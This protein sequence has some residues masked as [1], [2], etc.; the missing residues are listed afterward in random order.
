VQAWEKWSL[1]GALLVAMVAGWLG[2][3]SVL[4]STF[5]HQGWSDTASLVFVCSGGIT[6]SMTLLATGLMLIPRLGVRRSGIAGS[7]LALSGYLVCAAGVRFHLGW[8][9]LLADL[10]LEMGIGILFLVPLYFVSR[11]R[12]SHAALRIGLV[13][14]ASNLGSALHEITGD[15]VGQAWDR[16]RGAISPT[17]V[18]VCVI[19]VVAL[20]IWFMLLDRGSVGAEPTRPSSRRKRSWVLP[21]AIAYGC[22]WIAL[23]LTVFLE[24][25]LEGMSSS[26]VAV[27]HVRDFAIVARES[28]FIILSPIAGALVDRF[29]GRWLAAGAASFVA[30]S[31]AWTALGAGGW[32]APLLMQIL[33]AA[34]AAFVFTASYAMFLGNGG[35]GFI[36]I[37]A[38]LEFVLNTL[39]VALLLLVG[40]VRATDRYEFLVPQITMAVLCSAAIVLLVVA[41]PPRIAGP[42]DGDS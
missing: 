34:G 14:A 19:G 4:I 9:V 27:R 5:R 3:A 11:F 22:V 37:I 36:R 13:L 26:H 42:G 17:I 41:R 18:T 6:Q 31:S 38:I 33:P 39:G 30:L 12:R 25:A 23:V 7:L 40:S 21:V 1:P 2:G 16:T 20:S 29:G 35:L 32:L 10:A 15:L 28:T 24:N 8:L